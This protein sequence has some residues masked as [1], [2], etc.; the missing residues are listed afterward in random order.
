MAK[1]I[2]DVREELLKALKS[3]PEDFDFVHAYLD[4]YQE[5]GL[6]KSA[7]A[8]YTSIIQTLQQVVVWCDENPFS[9]LHSPYALSY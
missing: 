9:M 6:K 5:H 8:L 1:K 3:I 7:A 2:R 4:I